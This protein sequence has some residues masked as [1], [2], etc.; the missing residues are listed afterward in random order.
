MKRLLIIMLS[1]GLVVS[2]SAQRHGGGGGYHYARPHVTVV[3]GAYA[4]L[5]PYYGFGYS[6]FG[7]PYYTP[8]GYGYNRPSKLTLQ[9]EDIKNDY[10]DKISSAKHDKSLSKQQRKETVR[11][12]KRQRDQLIDEK[13]KNYYKE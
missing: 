5:Y 13:K 4:P 11:E 2:A 1:L 10:R 12:L 7:Y 6:P 3:Y 8:Y 9:I